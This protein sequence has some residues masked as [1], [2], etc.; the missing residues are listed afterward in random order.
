MVEMVV[1][2]SVLLWEGKEIQKSFMQRLVL[3]HMTG[4]TVY[5]FKGFSPYCG[6]YV[7]TNVKIFWLQRISKRFQWKYEFS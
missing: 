3:V 7:T 5:N 4:G 2:I 1:K 6:T